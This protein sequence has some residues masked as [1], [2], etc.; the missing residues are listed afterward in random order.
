LGQHKDRS[1]LRFYLLE[2]KLFEYFR[3]WY[4]VL[5]RQRSIVIISLMEGEKIAKAF[6]GRVELTNLFFFYF[7]LESMKKHL[8]E[9]PR[10][11]VRWIAEADDYCEPY[12]S[13]TYH[14]H[15]DNDNREAEMCHMEK[16]FL[17][18]KKAFAKRAS[19]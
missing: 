1:K 16:E 8:M 5:T 9:D 15:P 3:A 10:K 2:L 14:D 17:T 12:G 6:E 4:E 19:K 13:C 11:R 18:K 7:Q